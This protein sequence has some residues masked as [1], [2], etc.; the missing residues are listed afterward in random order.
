M[1]S[2]SHRDA[3]LFALKPS[4]TQLRVVEPITVPAG[5]AAEVEAFGA[6]GG[7]MQYYFENGIQWWIDNGFLKVIP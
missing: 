1:I 3:Y 6:E 2:D 7:G 5:P 4:R